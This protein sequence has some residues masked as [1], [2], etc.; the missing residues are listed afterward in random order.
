MVAVGRRIQA[1]QRAGLTPA[2][3]VLIQQ[4]GL[5]GAD[6]HGFEQSIGELQAP[7]IQGQAQ[8]SRCAPT[9]L[10]PGDPSRQARASSSGRNFH[11]SSSASPSGSESATMPQPAWALSL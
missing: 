5:T 10:T 2:L 8:L 4:T 9:A 3:Q 6:Q 1:Q 11:I 7:V